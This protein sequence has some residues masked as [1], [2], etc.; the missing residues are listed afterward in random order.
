[1]SYATGIR[2]QS[3]MA[4]I[5]PY[6]ASASARATTR[7]ALKNVSSRSDK[8]EIAAVPTVFIAHALAK[9]AELTDIAAESANATEVIEL[10]FS[11]LPV[12]CA[13][14]TIIIPFTLENTIIIKT[15]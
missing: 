4:T 12:V 8:E 2:V 13:L 5:K 6:T 10:K 9:T 1:M 3:K 11:E 15:N 14:A 7:N